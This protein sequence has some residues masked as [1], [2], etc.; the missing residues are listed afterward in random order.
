MVIM[1][2]VYAWSQSDDLS[3]Q[4]TMVFVT[5][6][7]GNVMLMTSYRQ[8]RAHDWANPRMVLLIMSAG[9]LTALA[10]YWPTA[11]TVFKFLPLPILDLSVAIF[12]GAMT[13]LG[14]YFIQTEPVI[15]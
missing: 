8:H 11:A 14:R 13:G 7:M 2:Y 3:W 12:F 5:V 9:F 6:V 1:S 15:F 4:R 10:V